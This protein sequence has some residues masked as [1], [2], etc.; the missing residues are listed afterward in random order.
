MGNVDVAGDVKII[1][2]VLLLATEV[3]SARGLLPFLV[4]PGSTTVLVKLT[5]GHYRLSDPER[6][7][8]TL[9]YSS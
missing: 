9:P 2:Y 8:T 6:G 3:A 5:G 7:Q 4:H 1:K